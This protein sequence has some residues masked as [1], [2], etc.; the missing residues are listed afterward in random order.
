MMFRLC[1]IERKNRPIPPLLAIYSWVMIPL[2][3]FSQM[4]PSAFCILVTQNES[5]CT[6]YTSNSDY[7]WWEITQSKNYPSRM[8]RM[9]V[10]LDRSSRQKYEGSKVQIN[11]RTI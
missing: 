6:V 2:S 4:K 7:L 10:I 11:V 1:C 5:P 9:V 3:V 8:K